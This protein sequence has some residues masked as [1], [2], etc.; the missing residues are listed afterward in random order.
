MI[1]IL[2][3]QDYDM[4]VNKT[5]I[6]KTTVRRELWQRQGYD[7]YLRNYL[8]NRQKGHVFSEAE[9]IPAT[10]KHHCLSPM[11][12]EIE[13]RIGQQVKRQR[14][15]LKLTQVQL[16]ETLGVTSQQI[17]KYEKG[18]DRLAASRLLQ[19]SKILGVPITFFYDGLEQE[20]DLR[21]TCTIS[22]GKQFAIKFVDPGNVIVDISVMHTF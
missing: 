9:F 5:E 10:L 14:Q 6:L 7:R 16:A 22:N 18:I 20:K 4:F 13:R 2:L 3:L 12:C 11:I 19:L 21:V 8:Q 1:A 17:H 15:V